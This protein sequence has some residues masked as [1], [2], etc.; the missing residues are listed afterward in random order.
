MDSIEISGTSKTP[1]VKFDNQT[2]ALE[3]SGRSIPENSY[4]FYEPLLS[5]LD[6]YASKPKEKTILTFKLDYFN[7]SSSMYILGILKKLEKL[8]SSGHDAE[9]KWF[10]DVDDEDMLQ[11]GEDFNQIVKIP[12]EMV[13]I[14][15]EE[16]EIPE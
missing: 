7:T 13:E 5:W 2:G 6:E 12:F 10:Y 3:I 16:E 1:D 4:Q 8:Y 11:T 14:D 9:I 15:Q